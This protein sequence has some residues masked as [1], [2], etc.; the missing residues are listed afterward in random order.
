MKTISLLNDDN[1]TRR[2]RDILQDLNEAL[3]DTF[4][5]ELE[6]RFPSSRY[7][8]EERTKLKRRYLP[9][10]EGGF[11]YWNDWQP[12]ADTETWPEDYHW[13]AVYPVTGNSEGHYLHIDLIGT[14]KHEELVRHIAMV[15]TFSGW[16]KACE[17]CA[18]AGKLLG[19]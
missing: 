3:W 11:H 18:A 2:I 13:I 10:M 1:T 17:V 15:K 12:G 9:W 14:A 6:E 4:P 5:E 19:A 7:T 16:D 8:P